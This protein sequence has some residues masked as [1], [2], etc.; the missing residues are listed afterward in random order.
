MKNLTTENLREFIRTSKIVHERG[1]HLES[2]SFP[3]VIENSRQCL[4]LR[5]HVSHN[6][7]VRCP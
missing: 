2:E 1:G 7:V 5:T 4:L 6:T 3:Q